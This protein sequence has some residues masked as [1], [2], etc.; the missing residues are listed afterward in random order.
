MQHNVLLKK[1]LKTLDSRYHSKDIQAYIDKLISWYMVKYSDRYLE[2]LFDEQKKDDFTILNVM[3]FETLQKSYTSFEEELFQS[4]NSGDKRIVLEKHLVIAAGWGL[5]YHKDSSPEFGFY[6]ATQLFNDFNPVY[7]WN[8]SNT[9][10][11]PVLE[12]N[13]SLENQ[14]ILEAIHRRERM[15]KKKNH[16]KQKTLTRIR[17]FFHR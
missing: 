7:G 5:I 13:Y 12:K 15:Q 1:I 6:R 11:K 16:C 2:G 4:S 10:Y 17:S 9:V 14:E 3:S 8:L